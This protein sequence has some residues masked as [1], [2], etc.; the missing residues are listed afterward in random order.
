MRK[1]TVLS[2][3]TLNGVMQAPS[4]NDEDKTAQT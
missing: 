4:G 3:I 2:R 1:I